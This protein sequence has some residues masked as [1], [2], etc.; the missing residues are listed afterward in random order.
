MRDASV[1]TIVSR[2]I[3]QVYQAVSG[4]EKLAAPLESAGLFPMMVVR[5][6]EVGEQT[7]TLPDMLKRIGRNFEEEVEMTLE[8]LISLI[9]PL[10][11]CFLAVI[12]GSIVLALFLPLIK[13]IET[14]GV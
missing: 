13:I 8:S 5:M 1:N 6:I 12:I 11:I 14:L 10:M 9:E 7:G 2:T 3:N 4:G